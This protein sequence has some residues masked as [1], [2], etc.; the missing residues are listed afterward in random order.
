MSENEQKINPPMNIDSCERAMLTDLINDVAASPTGKA[1]LEKAAA[2]GYTL[3]TDSIDGMGHCHAKDK[4]IVLSNRCSYD[5]LV[6]SLAHEARH[7]EQISKGAEPY[8]TPNVSLKDQ[9]VEKR[10][11]EADA[12]ATSLMVCQ[13]LK[14]QGNKAPMEAAQLHYEKE[15][16]AFEKGLETSPKEALTQAALAWYENKNRLFKHECRVVAAPVSIGAN[17]ENTTG[18]YKKLTAEDCLD[19]FC[20]FKDEP[21]FTKSADELKTPERAGISERLKYWLDV[22]ANL[23][24]NEG[25]S[26]ESSIASIPVYKDSPS[27]YGQVNMPPMYPNAFEKIE[28]YKKA[29]TVQACA[30]ARTNSGR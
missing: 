23:C 25:V 5:K 21:Y 1:L 3:S 27:L 6:S 19:R 29:R 10:L 11:M 7:A 15:I 16:A 17:F 2:L 18:Q 8:Y 24:K 20:S 30:A 9:L 28:A 22:N 12:V 13:E 4:R 26:Q 14:E